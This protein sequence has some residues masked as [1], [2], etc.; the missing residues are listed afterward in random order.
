MPTNSDFIVP[1]NGKIYTQKIFDRCSSLISHNIWSGLDIIKYKTWLNNFDTE[2]EQYFAACILDSLI[3][4]SE[5][6]TISLIHQLFQRT[7]PDLNRTDPMPL[8]PNWDWEGVVNS[9]IPQSLPNFRF[10]VVTSHL[11]RPHKSAHIV[12]RLMKRNLSVNQDLLINPWEIQNE[13]NKNIKTFFFIDDFLGT[14]QQFIDFFKFYKLDQYKKIYFAYV[15]WVAHKEG[16]QKVKDEFPILKVS[17]VET[18]NST[19]S[20]FSKD[21]ICFKD[22]KNTPEKAK[23]FYYEILKKNK[24]NIT[25]SD[26]RGYGHLELTYAFSHSIPDNCLPILWWG[27]SPGW[28]P[29]FDR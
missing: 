11:D 7:L 22:E 1:T 19:H 28:S 21:S 4:R 18:L 26:R 3:Y 14:G 12:A 25:D 17:A 20:I 10:V 8:N 23:F 29:L 15:P 27:K 5:D 16:I 2:E 13:I 24:I 9:N 6:Q